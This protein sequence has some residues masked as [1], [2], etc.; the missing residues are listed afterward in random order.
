MIGAR[1]PGLWVGY[2]FRGWFMNTQSRLDWR[3]LPPPPIY[4]ASA[5]HRKLPSPTNALAR[6]LPNPAL[7]QLIAPIS[8]SNPLAS[9]DFLAF[10]S[11]HQGKFNIGKTSWHQGKNLLAWREN[12]FFDEWKHP[13]SKSTNQ[14]NQISTRL[15]ARD[16]YSLRR[17]TLGCNWPKMSLNKDYCDWI[18][19]KVEFAEKAFLELPRVYVPVENRTPYRGAEG[20][21]CR[22]DF[23]VFGA[24]ST[25][26]K[27]L[28]TTYERVIKDL[29]NSIN[30]L[31]N[32]S[33]APLSAAFLVLFWAL[34]SYKK[35]RIWPAYI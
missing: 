8:A 7:A 21:C 13:P 11:W 17:G 24:L 27:S 20:H 28:S 30:D 25:T 14:P 23:W 33:I 35:H 3:K 18:S 4:G 1:Y 12:F 5:R 16:V 9:H 2:F 26:Y 19:T 15:V 6:A 34:G 10:L 22:F 31:W 29:Q 32:L